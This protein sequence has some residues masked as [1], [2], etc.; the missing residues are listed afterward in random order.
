MLY[1][2]RV[3][4]YDYVLDYTTPNKNVIMEDQEG[5]S[6]LSYRYVYGLDKVE[7]VI[8]GATGVGSTAQYVYN[9]DLGGLTSAR[10]TRGKMY[11]AP[12]FSSCISTRTAR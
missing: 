5:D 12:V 4:G 1:G 8:T 9:S 11:R 2:N 3:D 6:S 7:T 10:R